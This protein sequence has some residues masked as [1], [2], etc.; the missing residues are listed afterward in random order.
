MSVAPPWLLDH[1]PYVPFMERRTAHPPGLMPLDMTHWTV[2]HADFDAQMLRRAEVMRDHA[3]IVIGSRHEAEE[4]GVELLAMLKEHLG[5]DPGITPLEEFCV[6]TAIAHMVAEDFCLMVPDTASGEYKL[7]GA[8]LCFPSRWLLSEKLGRPMTVIHDPVPDYDDL[9]ARRV[10][11]VFNVLHVDR[12]LVRVNW[13]VHADPELFLPL[14]VDEKQTDRSQ[15]VDAIYLRTERQT[16]VRL[17]E[18]KA[19]AFGIKTSVTPLACLSP[20]EAAGLKAA[21][22]GYHGDE[23][24]YRSGSPVLDRARRQLAEIACA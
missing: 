24:A 4:P 20:A 13:L 5:M 16:L 9:L 2:R 15:N 14:G 10:N 11:R 7:A 8:I 22:E 18:S 17:P 1:A 12:P 19:V 3:D 23:I 6:W 21:L